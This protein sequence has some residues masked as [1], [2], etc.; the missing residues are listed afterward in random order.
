MNGVPEYHRAKFKQTSSGVW[1]CEAFEVVD[2]RKVN[3][4]NAGDEAMTKIEE[5]LGRHN[6]TVKKDG[7]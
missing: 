2:D 1:Y 6:K 4:L 5:I 7:K 3:I